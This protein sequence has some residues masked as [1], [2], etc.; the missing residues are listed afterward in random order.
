M[1][2]LRNWTQAVATQMARKGLDSDL[3]TMQPFVWI[4]QREYGENPKPVLYARPL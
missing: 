4:V 2:V 1:S 3:A